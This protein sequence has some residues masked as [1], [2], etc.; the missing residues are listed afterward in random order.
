MM[1]AGDL[2]RWVTIMAPVAGTE[3]AYGTS[4][5]TWGQIGE[6]AA[7]VQD[8]LP[9]RAERVAD[10]IDIGSRPSRVRMWWRD[11]I[12]ANMR[13]V[14][15]GRTMQIIA[16]PAELGRREGIEMIAVTVTTQGDGL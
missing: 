7:Q 1:R 10:G 6:G 8:M 11:D 13:L 16:G 4:S 5:Q 14:C 9:S 3:N 2:D 15:E 12:T